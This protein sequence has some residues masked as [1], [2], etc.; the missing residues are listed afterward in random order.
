MGRKPIGN[1][2]LTQAQR[3]AQLRQRRAE[4]CE[5]LKEARQL[6]DSFEARI[7]ENERRIDAVLARLGV[8]PE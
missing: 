6:L 8:N 4:R 7:A 5:Q 2:P 1:K 3:S